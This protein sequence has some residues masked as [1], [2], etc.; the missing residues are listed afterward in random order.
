MHLGRTK[1]H[2]TLLSRALYLWWE[3][4]ATAEDTFALAVD[5]MTEDTRADKIRRE[6][7]GGEELSKKGGQYGRTLVS[8]FTINTT[9]KKH[10]PK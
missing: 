1:S 2:N 6:N 10:R 9:T 5:S 3:P 7:Y 8:P 4:E